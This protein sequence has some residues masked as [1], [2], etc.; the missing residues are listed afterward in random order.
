[1]TGS[2]AIGVGAVATGFCASSWLE[3]KIKVAAAIIATAIAPTIMP[4][5]V[6]LVIGHPVSSFIR[7]AIGLQ[8]WSP[9]A[10]G[11]V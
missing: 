7:S 5:R 3:L 2:L 11:A 8:S 10:V 6:L 1:M 4:G 9:V